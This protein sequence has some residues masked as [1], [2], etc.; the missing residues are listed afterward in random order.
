MYTGNFFRVLLCLTSIHIKVIQLYTIQCVAVCH[1]NTDHSSSNH[2]LCRGCHES[3]PGTKQIIY[4]L[5]F[6]PP[7]SKGLYLLYIDSFVL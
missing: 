2:Q 7:Y 5:D 3:W 4:S 1:L 6:A